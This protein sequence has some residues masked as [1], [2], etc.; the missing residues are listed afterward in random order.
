MLPRN[1]LGPWSVT[2]PP[3]Q[4]KGGSSCSLM[5]IFLYKIKLS[6]GKISGRKEM[7]SIYRLR[8]LKAN[9][10]WG[11]T[12]LEAK[13]P[14][15]SHPSES[16]IHTWHVLYFLIKFVIQWTHKTKLRWENQFH[17]LISVRKLR[18]RSRSQKEGKP[19]FLCVTLPNCGG[20]ARA[21]TK[22]TYTNEWQYK[23][24]VWK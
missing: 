6:L 16:H 18:E 8:G 7:G 24:W 13:D 15:S 12:V 14:W 11:L 20:R 5:K 1:Q 3:Q 21:I 23:V 2:L 22:R 9:M 19:V 17:K 4:W 10:G